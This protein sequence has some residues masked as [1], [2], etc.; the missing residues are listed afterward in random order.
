MSKH[1][2]SASRPAPEERAIHEAA[3]WYARLRNDA[4]TPDLECAWQAWLAADG[5]HRLAWQK[6]E[7][8]C[9]QF[10][11]VPGRLA[12]PVLGSA[13]GRRSVLRGLAVLAVAGVG[14]LTA[15]RQA[16]WPE[17]ASDHRTATGE[18]RRVEL[19]DG[20]RLT[21]NA[22]SA[23]DVRF[24]A[25][26]RLIALHAGEILVSTHPDP[27]AVPRPFI[28]HTAHGSILAL[29]T[30]FNVRVEDGHTTVSVLEKAVE[31]GPPMPQLRRRVEAGQEFGFSAHEAGPLRLGD[32]FASTWEDGRLVVVDQPLERVL[33]ELSR[34]RSGHLACDPAVAGLRIS[35]AFPLDDTEQALAALTES[36]PL[37]IERFTRYWTRVAPRAG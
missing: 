13:P 27:A 16:P 17:W 30:R 31:A 28:V 37:R 25:G 32:A 5:A 15:W 9:G 36:F 12:V 33:A 26:S 29:G 21:L 24:S 11:R 23:V 2:A 19:A 20:S 18:R 22:R 8:V 7:A 3:A 1:A 6:V 14:G 10:G 4:A 35:G 34:Y